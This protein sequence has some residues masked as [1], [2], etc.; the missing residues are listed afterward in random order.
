MIKIH[1]L[2]EEEHF[3]HFPKKFV[4]LNLTTKF[5]QVTSSKLHNIQTC[6]YNAVTLSLIKN[7]IIVSDLKLFVVFHKWW[8]FSQ[9]QL[10]Q[11]GDDDIGGTPGFLSRNILIWLFIMLKKFEVV[12]E[13]I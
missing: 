12:L 5:Y 1:T 8:L 10:L 7:P 13:D 2:E 4:I 11:K 3:F 6:L 9:F